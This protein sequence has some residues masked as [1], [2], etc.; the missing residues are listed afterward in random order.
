MFQG[1][2][3]IL[4]YSRP[5][6]FLF[7]FANMKMDP[8]FELMTSPPGLRLRQMKKLQKIINERFQVTFKPR[9]I[10]DTLTFFYIFWDFGKRL[11]AK[12]CIKTK[13]NLF[14]SLSS[15]V[16]YKTPNSQLV[17]SKH[18]LGFLHKRYPNFVKDKK[19]TFSKYSPIQETIS[20][21]KIPSN[22]NHSQTSACK[23][24]SL[25]TFGTQVT[26][27]IYFFEHSMLYKN[28]LR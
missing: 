11:R 2:I 17:F 12:S 10:Q 9:L 4:F 8:L 3:Q 14:R 5:Q 13:M 23:L 16:L 6:I 15:R 7:Y 27:R 28:K 25:Q 18:F 20:D 21:Q 24:A 19:I 1:H 22:Q 26:L